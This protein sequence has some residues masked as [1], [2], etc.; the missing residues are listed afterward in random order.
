MSTGIGDAL[1][2]AREAQGR[3]VEDVAR[4][5]R[6]RAEQLRALEDERFDVFTGEVYAKGFLRSY[7]IELGLDHEEL[8]DIFRT[9]VSAP[10]ELPA[11]T[12]VTG[13]MPRGPRRSTPP[14]WLTWL[15]IGALVVAGLG[16]LGMISTRFSPDTASP[17]EPQGAPPAPAPPVDE[18]PD[19][20]PPPAPEP[21]PEPEFDGLEILV[22]LEEASW[23]RATVDGAVVFEGIAA[24]GETLQYQADDQ[25]A[26]RVGNAGGVRI[27]RNGTDLGAPGARGEVVEVTYDVDDPDP[28]A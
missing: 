4:V 5:I 25:I 22:A 28:V 19:T 16:F 1:R 10:N 26:L 8:L 14:A 6:S 23:L 3:T 24:A 12:L 9:R 15:F 17:D 11:S 7:A 2:E 21:D 18:G 27:Q 13:S 20:A